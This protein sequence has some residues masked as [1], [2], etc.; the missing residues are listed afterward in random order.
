MRSN[1]SNNAIGNTANYD[2]AFIDWLIRDCE[3]QAAKRRIESTREETRKALQ[4]N[5]NDRKVA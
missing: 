4:E 1:E 2:P 3:R 5:Q